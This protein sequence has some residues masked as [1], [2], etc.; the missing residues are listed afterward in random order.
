[1]SLISS[2]ASRLMNFIGH[3]SN[4]K[5]ILALTNLTQTGTTAY[6][7]Y[8]NAETFKYSSDTDIRITK[9]NASTKSL[10]GI[11]IPR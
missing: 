5:A 10:S 8:M 3:E 7:A 6:T 4:Q 2:V 1:M 9:L 11:E